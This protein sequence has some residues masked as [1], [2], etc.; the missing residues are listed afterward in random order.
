MNCLLGSGHKVSAS[1]YDT[2]TQNIVNE[3]LNRDITFEE[4]KLLA[5]K[6]KTGKASGLDMITAELLKHANDNFMLVFTKLFNKLLQSNSHKSES[7]KSDKFAQSLSAC[8]KSYTFSVRKS[9][10]INR[11]FA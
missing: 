5:K 9:D 10:F 3:T 1:A 11:I 2:L 4:V 7:H 8:Y 6:L